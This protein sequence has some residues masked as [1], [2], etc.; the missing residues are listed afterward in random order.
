MNTRVSQICEDSSYH[1]SLSFFFYFC[2]V[3][4]IPPYPEHVSIHLSFKQNRHEFEQI[5][6]IIAI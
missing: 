5:L 4:L 1:I 6:R 3:N 2:S